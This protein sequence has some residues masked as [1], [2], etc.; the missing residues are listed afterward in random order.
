MKKARILIIIAVLALVFLGGVFLWFW[1]LGSVPK[2]QNSEL[3]LAINQGAVYITRGGSFEEQARSGMELMVGD[4]LRTGKGSTASVLAYGMADLRLDQNTEIIIEDA[5]HN[6]SSE[7]GLGFRLEVGRTWSRLLHLLDLNSFYEVR[8]DSVVATVRGTAFVM[9]K[10]DDQV[11]VYVDHAGVR[12]KGN[13]EGVFLAPEDWS[14][15]EDGR[16]MAHGGAVSSSK[17][18]DEWLLNNKQADKNFMEAAGRMSVD[19]LQPNTGSAPDDWLYGLS[20]MSER[21]HMFFAG[22]KKD[23]IRAVYIARRLGYVRDLVERGKSG[24]AFHELTDV[25]DEVNEYLADDIEEVNK[26]KLRGLVGMFLLSFSDIMPEDSMYRL[27]LKSEEIYINLWEDGSEQNI[28]ARLLSGDAR[29]EEAERFDCKTQVNARLE[30]A[31]Q[32][33]EQTLTREEGEFDRWEGGFS[34]MARVL[35]AE[36]LE[37]Q[38]I[39][40]K[41][42]LEKL[43]WCHAPHDLMMEGGQNATSTTSTTEMATG[44]EMIEADGNQMPSQID[45]PVVEVPDKPPVVNEPPQANLNL[46]K[47]E[48]YAQPNPANKGDVVDLYVKGIR[49][50][51]SSLDVTNRAIFGL[52]GNIGSLRG[53]IYNATVAGSVVITAEVNDQGLTYS[54]RVSLIINDG[55][56]VLESLEVLSNGSQQIWQGD[57]RALTVI[58]HYSNGQTKTVT[59]AAKYTLSDMRLGHMSGTI[60]YA[61]FNATGL[62]VINASYT[63]EG[64]TKEAQ[65][66]LQVIADKYT[67]TP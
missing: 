32:V 38:R 25:E 67:T 11:E 12:V 44:T 65:T 63:E 16:L 18:M 49:S 21:M 6:D 55:P 37:M 9:E 59:N 14:R 30:E 10:E 5:N 61:D 62:E 58:A 48:L 36:K 64:V 42:L 57:N 1:S 41:V 46:S 60:F 50:D 31:L 17:Q 13:G 45:K 7:L 22:D 43:D 8:T 20:L 29:L 24:L 35:I 15:Y 27:K 52:I 28:F 39:R 51:G 2:I 34:D 26:T 40:Q 66:T 33:V 53:S 19:A 23:E 54:A 47:I 4:K 56:V 3:K